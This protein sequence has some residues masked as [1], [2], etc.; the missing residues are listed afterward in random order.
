MSTNPTPPARPAPPP[1]VV[2]RDLWMSFPGQRSSEP[3]HVL[4]RCPLS[5]CPRGDPSEFDPSVED[6][7][8]QLFDRL[9]EV[10]SLHHDLPS[11]D[12]R[13]S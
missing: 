5:A 11:V 3:V 10:L 12:L 6:I 1:A 9:D 4:E 8:L 7:G 13:G 2:V